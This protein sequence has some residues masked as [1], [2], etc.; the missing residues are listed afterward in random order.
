MQDRPGAGSA[1]SVRVGRAAARHHGRADRPIAVPAARG[2]P[3]GGRTGGTSG[4]VDVPGGPPPGRPLGGEPVTTADQLIIPDPVLLAYLRVPARPGLRLLAVDDLPIVDEPV[5]PEQAEAGWPLPLVVSQA[6]ELA[7][8][9]I[10]RAVGDIVCADCGAVLAQRVVWSG[11]A[12]IIGLVRGRRWSRSRHWG[13]LPVSAVAAARN[14]TLW[15][16]LLDR[17]STP[18]HLPLS[19]PAHGPLSVSAA[20]LREAPADETLRIAPPNQW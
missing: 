10:D 4:V 14:R 16:C 20:E 17:P 18:R 5:T 9:R 6:G 1:P 7:G 12:A 19:C 11:E 15:Y 13:R 2:G 3:G 8:G